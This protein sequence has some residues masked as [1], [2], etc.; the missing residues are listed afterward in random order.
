[1]QEGVERIFK[2]KYTVFM[3]E[4]PSSFPGPDGAAPS[5]PSAPSDRGPR[6]SFLIV[7]SDK[8]AGP[9]T[10]SCVFSST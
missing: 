1:M 9:L 5:A 4:E 8:A 6:V 3:L 2:G 10:L 7:P